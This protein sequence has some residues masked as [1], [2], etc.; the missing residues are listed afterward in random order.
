MPLGPEDPPALPSS[1]AIPA[2][3]A[4][5]GRT[6]LRLHNL[7]HDMPPAGGACFPG[8]DLWRWQYFEGA[9]CPHGVVVPVD[10]PTAWQLYPDA[11][12]VYDK[13][14]VCESQGIPHGPHGVM[15]DRFPVFSKPIMNLHGMGAGGRIIR[16]AAEYEA[17]FTPGHMW[18]PLLTG[19]HVSTDVAL[20]DGAPRWWRHTEGKRL[21]EGMFDYWTV[22]GGRL[23]R[24]EA[25]LRAWIRRYLRRFTGI[26]N[27]EAIGM[28]ISEVHLRMSEQWL[29]LNG[30]GWLDAVV[31]LYA[32]GRWQFRDRRRRGYSVILFGPHG[33]WYSIDPDAVSALRVRPGVSSIQI[34]FDAR[35]PL[36][37]HAMPPGGFRLAIVNCW[38]LGVG[39]SVRRRLGGL[40]TATNLNGEAGTA[41]SPGGH[42][43]GAGERLLAPRL[44]RDSPRRAEVPGRRPEHGQ[45]AR[46]EAPFRGGDG[47]P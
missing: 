40:F 7:T 23:P 6:L 35:K 43:R 3:P 22:L 37:Q 14:F 33:L 46:R 8:V 26:V 16:S 45:S 15:P 5:D 32:R 25:H 9:V 27:F 1:A 41:P 31:A 24:L 38:D 39:R 47:R 18:M 30:P 34:T 13:L 42:P 12:R 44:G 21:G 2:R 20:A 36:E 4:R 19:P 28:V 11:R 17:H 10:D 29:D